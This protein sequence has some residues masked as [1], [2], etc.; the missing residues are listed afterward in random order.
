MSALK[1]S[2]SNSTCRMTNETPCNFGGHFWDDV[3][4]AGKTLQCYHAINNPIQTCRVK[5]FRWAP[6]QSNDAYSVE[7]DDV[8]EIPLIF[9]MKTKLTK[10]DSFNF[11]RWASPSNTATV[12]LTAPWRRLFITCTSDNFRYYIWV[13]CDSRC[14]PLP[15]PKIWVLNATDKIF[16]DSTS[17]TVL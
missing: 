1:E 9:N 15:V 2:V 11:V 16:V 13:L 5:P 4:F 10:V 3:Q 7:I 6:T 12:S 17:T 8:L 14:F